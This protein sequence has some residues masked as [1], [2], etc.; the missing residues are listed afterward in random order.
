MKKFL[1]ILILV[2]LF[3]P[4]IAAMVLAWA[5]PPV[6]FHLTV[7]KKTVGGDGSFAFE[8]AK[9]DE[10]IPV[11]IKSLFSAFA[12]GDISAQPDEFSIFTQN[13]Q[14][15]YS[16][17]YV[18]HDFSGVKLR[19][20]NVSGWRLKSIVC[21]KGNEPENSFFYNIFDDFVVFNNVR[22]GDEIYC[23]FT[24]EKI[25]NPV[26]IKRIPRGFAPGWCDV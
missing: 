8:L 25:K 21:R 14:G 24:N 10:L 15:A 19:E 3:L 12:S 6:S 2:G 18:V 7:A 1:P 23:E 22:D 9:Q 16:A 4:A 11:Q 5:I 26:L 13:G 17:D 20:I